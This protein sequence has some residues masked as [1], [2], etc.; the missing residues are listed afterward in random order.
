[1]SADVLERSVE[2]FFTTKGVGKGT[3]LG[4]AMASGFVRQSG[5]R[6]EIASE[7]GRGTVIR[8]IF[9]VTGGGHRETV[10]APHVPAVVPVCAL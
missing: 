3:G 10:A 1:M 2:P 9:P 6:L 7:P 5:G 8:M 4:L